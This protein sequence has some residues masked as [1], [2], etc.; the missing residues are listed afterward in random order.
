M[1]ERHDWNN[2]I[3]RRLAGLHLAPA[4][5]AEIVDEWTQHLEESYEELRAEGATDDEARRAVLVT[6]SIPELAGD[7]RDFAPPGAAG[8][9]NIGADLLQDLRYAARNLRKSPA[10]AVFVILTLALGIGAN[11]TVFTVINTVLLNPLPIKGASQLVAV[12]TLA[13]GTALR[14]GQLLPVSYLNLEDLRDKNQVFT[15]L[16]GYTPLMPLTLTTAAGS[17][18][19]FAELVTANYFE[20]LGLRPVMGRFFVPEEDRTPGAHAVIVIGYGA[21]QQRL[22]GAADVIGCTMRINGLVFTIAGVAPEGFKGVNAI[23]GPDIWVPAMMAEQLLPAQLRNALRERGEV[24]F[25]GAARLKPGVSMRLAEANLKTIAAGLEKEYPDANRGHTIALRSLAEAAQGDTR[26]SALFGGIVLMA[27]VGL[28]L[29]IACSNVANLLLARAAGRRQEIAVRLALGAGR[30]RLIRQ[31]LTESSLLGVLSGAVGLILADA[32]CRLLWSARPV[33]VAQNFVDL[34]MDAHVFVFALVVSLIT[35][36]LF[37]LVP[38]LQSSRAEVVEALKEETRTAGRS[39]RRITFANALLVGQVALSLVSVITAALFFRSIQRAYMIDPGFQTDRLAIFMMNPGQAGYGRARTEQFYR[40]VR[41]QVSAMPGIA[42]VSWSSNLPLW[43][44]LSR[45][46]L[47][48][49]QTPQRQSDTVTAVVDTIDLSYFETTGIALTRGRDFTDMDR[50]GSL[51]AAIVNETMAAKYWPNQ[52]PLGKRFRFSGDKFLRQIVGVVKTANYQSLNEAPQPAVYLPLRQNF[53]DSMILH[54]RT[55]R[56][57]AG[58]LTAVQREVRAIDSHLD[59]TDVRTGRKIIDQALFSARIGVG[60]LGVF[61]LLALG[62]ASVGLYGILAYSVNQRRH[63][64]GVRMSLGADQSR[65][66]WMVLR[67]GMMLVVTGIIVGLVVSF[68]IDRALSKLL[69]GVS[70]TDPVSLAGASLT[71]LTVAAL[72][73]YLPARGASRVDPLVALREG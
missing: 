37:G 54:V 6:L 42:S 8:S 19:I 49:G 60:L 7:R 22:G 4:R 43:A 27:I 61:G 73:C 35:G 71:L 10:F 55:E 12:D 13:T 14:S 53:S 34:K 9:G 25:H 65:V 32:G 38:A 24:F 29:L 39:R 41:T 58:V 68:L 31:L 46:I 47:I 33:E 44:R 30:G 69:Y 56:D 23:F 2:E 11:T 5:E 36:L 16:A 67:Q 1:P 40:D 72:A 66:L 3:R 62:L 48:E 70:A 20:T 59:V 17:E 52:D 57:P 28:V 63:E 15:N 64:I 21:W 45:G 18:R 26:Q 51:P 50:D